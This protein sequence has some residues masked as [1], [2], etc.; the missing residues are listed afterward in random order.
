MVQGVDA[1]PVAVE[2]TTRHA[3]DGTPRLLGLVDACVREAYHR[4]LQAFFALALPA[5]RGITTV[6]FAPAAL[7]KQGSG[8]DL[9]LALALA[10]AGGLFAP[11]RARGLFAFGEISLRGHVLPAR[12]AVSVA[13][14]ARAAGASGLLCSPADAALCTVVEGLAVHAA[15]TLA[16]A[17]HWLA[18]HREL[19]PPTAPPAP[20]TA[21]LPDL[22]DLRGL[23]SQKRALAVA[24][25]GGHNL[26]LIGPPGTGKSALLRRLPGLLPPPS[27]GERLAI[28]QTHAAAGLPL[29][30]PTQRPF[31]APHHTSSTASLLGGGAD[32]RPGEVTLAHC[33]VL[34]LDELPEFRRDALEAL[35]QP[36]E[37]GAVT[38]G[39]AQRTVTM[40]AAFLL[41]AAMNPCPCGYAGHR[42]RP[43]VCTPAAAQRY[44]AR[45]S[46]PLLDRIDLCTEVPALDPAEL[47]GPPEPEG[48]TAFWRQRI[49]VARQRMAARQPRLRR[50]QSNARLDG[51]DLLLA[52]EA[53]DATLRLVD[54]VLRRRHESGRGRVRLLRLA[55]TLADLADRAAIEAVDVL[56]AAAL[57]GGVAG[58]AM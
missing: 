9:P 46:G 43:C 23:S 32:A 17:V 1:I 11:E 53:D 5:P 51:R 39:R 27:P 10:G 58:A 45:L 57:R 26:L 38:V 42:H 41:V 34:F 35:R 12:G 20:V 16:D 33:G 49:D 4:V 8:F 18:G 25:A 54:D 30:D 3:S 47:R 56:E 6:N 28:L 13:L 50:S 52:C 29:P 44:R 36:L 48:S 21:P 15:P 37:D 19:P 2:A 14:A 7:R 55:R 22:A 40:P 31:R 24:A